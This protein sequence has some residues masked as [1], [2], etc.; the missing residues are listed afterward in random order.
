MSN[1]RDR[2]PRRSLAAALALGLVAGPAAA[3]GP[4]FAGLAGSDA[5]RHWLVL[6]FDEQP[7]GHQIARQGNA[8]LQRIRDE[9][10]IA[11]PILPQPQTSLAVGGEFPLD[12]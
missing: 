9:I 8:A 3:E 2:M 5:A 6:N 11:A 1:R 4:F 7:V 10:R 12:G